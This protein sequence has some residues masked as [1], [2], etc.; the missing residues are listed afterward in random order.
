MSIKNRFQ[1]KIPVS[2]D[3][4]IMHTNI[5]APMW[6]SYVMWYWGTVV[7]TVL[8]I[9]SLSYSGHSGTWKKRTQPSTAGQDQVSCA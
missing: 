9:G 8:V 5:S 2:R 3:K 1:S 7:R 6:S 4:C